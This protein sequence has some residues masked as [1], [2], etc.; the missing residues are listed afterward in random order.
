MNANEPAT[1]NTQKPQGTTGYHR[2]TQRRRPWVASVPCAVN[3]TRIRAFRI[4]IG[5]CGGGGGE[6]RREEEGGRGRK[7][8]RKKDRWRVSVTSH[9]IAQH[10]TAPHSTTHT[11]SLPPHLL[12]PHAEC[13]EDRSSQPPFPRREIDFFVARPGAAQGGHHGSLKAETCME[14]VQTRDARDPCSEPGGK[15][16]SGCGG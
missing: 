3:S 12:Q 11:R 14:V 10:H 1:M 6:R 16:W 5:I 8:E 7:K 13:K 4:V 15:G 9:S 2:G